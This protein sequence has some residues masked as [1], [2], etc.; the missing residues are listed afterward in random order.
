M[1]QLLAS[2]QTCPV[3]DNLIHVL[4]ITLLAR[5]PLRILYPG[6][7]GNSRVVVLTILSLL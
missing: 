1:D 5:I 3:P 7:A 6:N 4:D 2:E